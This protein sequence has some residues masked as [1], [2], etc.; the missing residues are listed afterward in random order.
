[1]LPHVRAAIA[2]AGCAISGKQ[3]TAVYD[4]AEGRY[5]SIGGTITAKSVQAYDYE[6]SCHFSG[7]HDGNGYALYHYG[8]SCHVSLEIKGTEF[9]G[10]DY[11]SSSHY[12]GTADRSG[13]VNLYDFG[14]GKYYSFT[15]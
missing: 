15:V 12:Q 1:M 2:F 7:D 3:A 13:L 9:S 8:E 11:C 10:Y 4:H 5:R 14:E 6:N